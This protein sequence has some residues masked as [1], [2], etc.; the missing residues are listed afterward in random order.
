MA[1]PSIFQP[2]ER[3]R[4][5]ASQ[6]DTAG[7]F[8][9][10]YQMNDK[11]HA[12]GEWRVT[13][14]DPEVTDAI[15]EIL[16]GDEAQ[17]WETKG[18]DN[19]EVFTTSDSV[20]I[21]LDDEDAIDARMVVWPQRGKDKMFVCGGEP[22]EV[23]ENRRPFEC[24]EGDYTTRAEHDEQGHVCEPQIKIRFRIADAPDLGYFEFRTGSWS[25]TSDIG[26]EIGALEDALEDGDG[27]V[28]ATLHLEPV[29]FTNNK[30][31][32]IQFTKPVL[33]VGARVE[34]EDD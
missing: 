25:M 24:E 1:R 13:S 2:R 17:E 11:P 29:E 30:G 23:D 26:G 15:Q 22:F 20:E 12:L 16:G 27:P 33:T 5:R 7:R 3:V 8:R 18:E 32:L 34:V 6:G 28:A 10:G 4:Q 14:G 19:L 21:L 9:S 31:K